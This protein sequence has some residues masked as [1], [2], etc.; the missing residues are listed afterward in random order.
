MRKIVP[1]SEIWGES[2]RD[3]SFSRH[4]LLGGVEFYWGRTHW[5]QI[6]TTEEVRLYLFLIDS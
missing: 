3:M 5:D 2:E 4:T 6:W 1:I